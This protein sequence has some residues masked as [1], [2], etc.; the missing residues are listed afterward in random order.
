[1]FSILLYKGYKDIQSTLDILKGYDIKVLPNQFDIKREVRECKFN[2]IVILN[3]DITIP[4]SF[5]QRLE[6]SYKPNHIASCRIDTINKN[7]SLIIDHRIGNTMTRDMLNS[8][9][10]IFNRLNT[11]GIYN[12]IDDVIRIQL[13]LG[14]K[15]V[16][17]NIK[18][19]DIKNPKIINH[20]GPPIIKRTCHGFTGT[21]KRQTKESLLNTIIRKPKNMLIKRKEKI[22]QITYHNKKI[23]II[24]PFMYNGDRYDLFVASLKS[25]YKQFKNDN[26]VDILVHETSP[27]RYITDEFI[28]KYN[29]IYHWSKWDDVFH[30]AWALNM[31]ARYIAKGDIF[32]FFDADL[33]VNKEW[34]EELLTCDPKSIYIGW[35]TINNM[36]EKSTLRYIKTGRIDGDY[37]R[38]R[39]PD[40]AGAA[41]GINIFPRDIFFKVG[42]WPEHF[43]GTYGGEDNA[44]L[45]KLIALGYHKQ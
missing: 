37:Q 6:V 21:K 8:N 35:G 20:A 44:L 16:L 7:G 4:K 15:P 41:G 14:Y 19:S 28:K 40:P 17:Y 27:E 32:V 2:Y 26:N 23:T 13:E 24:I 42:G 10:L 5:I 39:K 43:D 31:P 29:L 1:M 9:C 30:R 45:F 22:K 11:S 36:T 25:L 38:I 18:L 33:L 34:K 3:G 12:T